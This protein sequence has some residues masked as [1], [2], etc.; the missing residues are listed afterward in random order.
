MAQFH[1]HRIGAYLEADG[2]AA[3]SAVPNPRIIDHLCSPIPAVLKQLKH[4]SSRS[5]IPP[6]HLGP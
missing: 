6:K 4:F 1:Q 5:D 3:A 2:A